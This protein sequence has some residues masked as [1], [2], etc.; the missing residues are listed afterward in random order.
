MIH[1]YV[2]NIHPYTKKEKESYDKSPVR[3]DCYFNYVNFNGGKKYF[4]EQ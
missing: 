1:Y 3:K 4:K 2:N